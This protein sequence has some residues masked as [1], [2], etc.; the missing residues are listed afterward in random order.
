M[1]DKQEVDMPCRTTFVNYPYY[2]IMLT[3]SHPS[4]SLD[5]SSTPVQPLS[6]EDVS[7]VLRLRLQMQRQT[8][9]M[10]RK[11][12]MVS[13]GVESIVP[14]SSYEIAHRLTVTSFDLDDQYLLRTQGAT[15]S[16]ENVSYP[17]FTQINTQQ[18]V[19]IQ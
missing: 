6:R 8:L 13:L 7:E 11:Y 16:S 17:S 19:L 9:Q 4:K 3:I 15:S 18:A 12:G 14:A 1:G 2:D 5:R 10:Y